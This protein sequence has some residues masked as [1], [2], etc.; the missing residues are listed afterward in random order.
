M[1]VPNF[2]F[3]LY[4]SFLS[5]LSHDRL[6]I[7]L[8]TQMLTSLHPITH[9][10]ATCLRG[11]HSPKYLKQVFTRLKVIKNFMITQ[12]VHRR[13]KIRNTYP[14]KYPFYTSMSE[15][16][17]SNYGKTQSEYHQCNVQDEICSLKYLAAFLGFHFHVRLH[18]VVLKEHIY[19]KTFSW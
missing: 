10:M 7:F 4:P 12:V 18:F 5:D 11:L 8:V 17:I 16:R 14:I 6:Q 19:T 9:K 15:Y 1:Q 2:F 3:V 13:A